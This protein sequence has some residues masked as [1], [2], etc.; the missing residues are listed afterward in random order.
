MKGL[1]LSSNLNILLI[2]L[3]SHLC[4]KCPHS[5]AEVLWEPQEVIIYSNSQLYSSGKILH[6]INTQTYNQHTFDSRGYKFSFPPEEF[7][8]K[9]YWFGRSVPQ[10]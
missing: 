10:K 8:I 2:S 3:P 4:W 6:L 7:L 1:F 5:F 9:S